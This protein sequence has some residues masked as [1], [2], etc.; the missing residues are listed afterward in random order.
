LAYFAAMRPRAFALVCVLV[1]AFVAGCMGEKAPMVDAQATAAHRQSG[2]RLGVVWSRHRS[3]VERLVENLVA[4]A[5][6][7]RDVA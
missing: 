1:L 6:V 7:A 4:N 5:G 2:G 3:E